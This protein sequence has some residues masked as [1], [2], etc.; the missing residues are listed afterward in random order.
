MHQPV[1]LSEVI[2]GMNIQPNGI[3]IDA[4]F[5]RGG[6]S[7]AILKKLDKAGRLIG[8]DKDSE[9][10]KAAKQIKDNRFTIYHGS[11]SEIKKIAGKEN[12]LGDVSGILLDLGVSSPQL[13]TPDRGFSFRQEGPLDMRM[14]T[15]N[16]YPLS[17]HLGKL[18][19]K[20]L[21]EIIR[22][23]GEEKFARRIAKAI[24]SARRE[25]TF[26][27]TTQLA[28]VVAKAHPAWKRGKHPATQTFQALRIFINQELDDLKKTLP[29]CLD[30]LK[31]GGRL[32][33]ISFHSLEDRMVKKFIQQEA[34]GSNEKSLQKIP[35][36]QSEFSA[37][38]R[39]V[40]R[41]IRP[42]AAEVNTN[43]RAQSAVLRI[44][45]KIK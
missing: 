7:R 34:Q 25:K 35:L 26:T 28:E 14:D 45:E 27:T 10:V 19:E 20:K 33:A 12:C 16:N 6:H 1:L 3:Y 44:V 8:I 9:A 39:C 24:V 15:E 30:V 22:D 40:G 31:S 38:V 36:R 18:S 5:G 41:A 23:Y 37:R 29:D 11:F 21:E 43:P 32:L 17:W 4:T 2:E 13:D 42:C